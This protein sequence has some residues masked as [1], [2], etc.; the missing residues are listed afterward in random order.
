M[1]SGVEGGA[2]ASAA[3]VDERARAPDEERIRRVRKDRWIGY[4]RATAPLAS[5]DELLSCPIRTR[6]PNLI[7]VGP[8][9]NGKSMIIEK[10]YR[11]HALGQDGTSMRAGLGCPVLRVQMPAAPD[12]RRFFAALLA[13]LGVPERAH[14]RLLRESMTLRLMRAAEVRILVIDLC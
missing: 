4:T 3:V 14:E 5:L 13:L 12:E 11:R 10:F 7:L 9:N 2:V 6:M 1:N 8:T